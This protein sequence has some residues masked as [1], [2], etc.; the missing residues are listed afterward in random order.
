MMWL[1]DK[2][3]DLQ[4]CYYNRNDRITGITGMIRMTGDDM[5][6]RNEDVDVGLISWLVEMRG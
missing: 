5:D 1:V 4:K 2:S 3:V 6:Y